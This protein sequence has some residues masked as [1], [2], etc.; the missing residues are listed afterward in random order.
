MDAAER[1]LFCAPP[2]EHKQLRIDA[3]VALAANYHV[4]KRPAE[5][6][7]REMRLDFDDVTIAEIRRRAEAKAAGVRA[8]PYESMRG[9]SIEGSES[10]LDIIENSQAAAL[11]TRLTSGQRAELA[12]IVRGELT[13]G[14]VL[15]LHRI[16]ESTHLP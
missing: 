13:S 8:Y 11:W 9:V 6:L 15:D 3:F 1:A 14:V 16:E 4:R 5:R 10:D 2:P 7:Y 12:L